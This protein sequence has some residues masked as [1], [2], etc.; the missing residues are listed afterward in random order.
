MNAIPM[1]EFQKLSS[2][3][4]RCKITAPQGNISY[5]LDSDNQ[6]VGE[7]NW[8]EVSITIYES[9][10]YADEVLER[11]GKFTDVRRDYEISDEP[12]VKFNDGEP[13]LT[14]YG[15]TLYDKPSNID[16]STIDKVISK[17][18]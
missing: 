4:S 5:I 8:F 13:T 15:K 9:Y 10:E 16:E 18:E 7:I 12:P 14:D 11:L 1:N 2:A 3:M 17:Y 6:K